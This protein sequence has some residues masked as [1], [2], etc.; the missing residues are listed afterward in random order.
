MKK[1]FYI[2]I[3]VISFFFV[4]TAM[5]LYQHTIT[6]LMEETKSHT[7]HKLLLLGNLAQL[8]MMSK[9]YSQIEE[10]IINFGE[11]DND[12]LFAEVKIANG[13]TIAQYG[14]KALN[15]DLINVSVKVP[16]LDGGHLIYSTSYSSKPI[17]EHAKVLF[18]KLIVWGIIITILL[19]GSLWLMIYKVA[20]IP[21]SKLMAGAQKIAQGD[22]DHAISIISNDEFG[23]LA[24]EFNVMTV[25]LK[26]LD[27]AN[28]KALYRARQL[29]D[30]LTNLPNPALTIDR[31]FVITFT[32][33]A[34]A[35]LVGLSPEECIGQYCYDVICNNHCKSDECRVGQAM[36]NDRI[37]QGETVISTAERD[38][39]IRYLGA[40]IHDEDG[41]VIGALESFVDVTE[42]QNA[43]QV[44]SHENRLR[45]GEILVN[46]EMQGQ[47]TIEKLCNGILMVLCPWLDVQ[48]GAI[49]VTDEQL[50]LQL[51]G[52]YAIQNDVNQTP[53]FAFGDGIAGQ[54][55]LQRKMVV[56]RDLPA[57]SIKLAGSSFQATPVTA[58]AVPLIYEDIV[59]GVIEV[60]CFSDIKPIDLD[61]LELIADNI[62]FAIDSV[63]SREQIETL[64]KKTQI[65]AEK[66]QAQQE[67]LH[68]TNE[69]LE[70]QTRVLRNSEKSLQ[71][72]Q[73][74]LQATNEE[75]E[76]KTESLTLQKAEIESK[77]AAL[78]ASRQQ[79][80]K[81]AAELALAN[82][83]K[84]EFLANMSHELRTPLNSLLLLSRNLA[85]N[86]SANLTEA[87]VKSS[88]TIYSSGS[89]LL[90]L[91]NEVL[92]LSKIESGTMD[93]FPEKI[94]VA[95]L[96]NDIWNSFKDLLE[97]KG[98]VFSVNIDK[99]SP[100]AI[101]TDKQRLKQILKNL[102]SN[103]LKFT[104]EGE[105]SLSVGPIR[106]ETDLRVANIQ[107]EDFIA[108]RVRDTGI[109]IAPGKHKAIFEAFQQA[110]GST[111][112]K[113]GG[114]GLGLSISRELAHLLGGRIELS[115]KPG[116]GST[117]TLIIPV[118]FSENSSPLRKSIL[119]PLVKI[120]DRGSAKDPAAHKK[121]VAK[122]THQSYVRDD[123][124]ILKKNDAVLLVIEDDPNFARVLRD[125]GREKGFKCL[126]ALT[127]ED[128]LLCAEKYAPA[129]II[130]D[131][132]LPVMD[133]WQVL[134]SLKSNR[135]LR[136]IPVHIV[137]GVDRSIDIFKKGIIGYVT[138][139]ISLE[140]LTDIFEKLNNIISRKF[141]KLL[142]VED[143]EILAQEIAKLIGNG[144]VQSTTAGSGAE[145]INLFKQTQFDCM[146]LDIG[147][148]DM[149]GFELLD[150]LKN[151]KGCEIPPIIIYTGRDLTKLEEEFIRR[152]TDS[153]IVKGVKSQER[154]LDETALFL[155]R[156]V[157]KMD[158]QKKKIIVDLYE[159]DA[160][161]KD[162]TILLVDDDMRTSFAMC[163]LLEE[164]GMHVHIAN[165][166]QR[167]LDLLVQEETIDL[168]LMDIMM[169]GMDG[170]EAMRKIRERE[171]FWNLPII[172]L[173]AK[174]MP[175]DK[176][177]CMAAG[178]SDYLTKPVDEGRLLS[179]LR[180]WLYR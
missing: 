26:S 1:I 12:I 79:I 8:D 47:L 94:F 82:K 158:T 36:L 45:E 29:A 176:I 18:F 40:P 58:V 124:D 46:D 88:E 57:D 108:I 77:N 66:L 167:A 172:A 54:A 142:I 135:N 16:I 106:E 168:V 110:D 166:G 152:Y 75:L 113:Y 171:S 14:K 109:G 95:E 70:G 42:L 163:Q 64:F 131:I 115:S 30:N 32:N 177:K 102:L 159:K 17:Q 83:Y 5:F 21:M 59:K 50:H 139:P 9:D 65:L 10:N 49:Y 134:E 72:Q 133:G 31:D 11:S 2:I 33:K 60:G 4:G 39:P 87:Q 73:E 37:S 127:G 173:T 22:L 111:S 147:L 100:K 153:I 13:F 52:G 132:I 90:E 174:A 43:L 128:G 34:A 143:N 138:K 144:D 157:G 81:K 92:N 101:H 84:S 118:H 155:H 151:I 170:Y 156:A 89:D 62:A 41:T 78:E 105:I 130:L 103:A 56:M 74:E 137:S 179:M 51:K 76:E 15:T 180:V 161:F 141:S 61:F 160:S 71:A 162:K 119:T 3:T 67:E 149:S 53:S 48:V 55:A 91:I 120:A 23:Q 93:I 123:R 96:T 126:V 19:I 85:N 80:E 99:G 164:K 6:L 136:H 63:Q 68:A 117:F 98:L 112:R 175:E 122:K 178:A 28:K 27:A 97:D 129:A 146:V 125:Q 148:P 35:S 107:P 140:Q 24:S 121:K 69:E 150:Q 116:V 165:E 7:Q 86:A 145:V 114:T 38:I 25:R 104:Q 20:V 169:P 154:L 44:V